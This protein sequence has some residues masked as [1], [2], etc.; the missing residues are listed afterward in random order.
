MKDFFL[1]FLP[2]SFGFFFF[3]LSSLMCDT[4][5]FMHV[6]NI[7]LFEKSWLA[8]N[9]PERMS[10]LL[11]CSD[12]VWGVVEQPN[13][14]FYSGVLILMTS[15]PFL[16]GA[17][18]KN[19]KFCTSSCFFFFLFS[20]SFS[21]SKLPL[22]IFKAQTKRGGAFVVHHLTKHYLFQ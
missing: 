19:I 20:F 6:Y 7:D 10:M 16:D 18:Q 12:D 1:F 3:L 9:L 17:C 5:A 13:S 4:L 22:H 2:F 15:P 21:I 14:S 11:C 8:L